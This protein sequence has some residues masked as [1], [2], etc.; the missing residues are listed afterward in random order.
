MIDEGSSPTAL[1]SWITFDVDTQILT[2]APTDLTLVGSTYTISAQYS[3]DNGVAS[4]FDVLTLTIDCRVT[5][6]T[7]P[8]DPTDGLTYYIS[9]TP[10][11]FFFGD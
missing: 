2:A 3:P 10:L 8:D 9:G 5:S 11:Y 1:P 4:S 7:K 6:F